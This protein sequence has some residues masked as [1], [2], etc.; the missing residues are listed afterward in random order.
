MK[1]CRPTIAEL[2]SAW[3]MGQPGSLEALLC[4]IQRELATQ[5]QIVA[6]REAPSATGA[7]DYP[8]DDPSDDP[9]DDREARELE[10]ITPTRLVHE[11]FLRL[12][13]CEAL[14]PDDRARFFAAAARLLRRRVVETARTLEAARSCCRTHLS[15]TSS[16][17]RG[18]SVEV[19]LLALDQAMSQ[20]EIV[21]RRKAELAELRFFVGL[22]TSE[23][24]ALLGLRT[25]TVER[26]WRDARFWLFRQLNEKVSAADGNLGSGHPGRHWGA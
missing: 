14:E 22:S 18:S 2:L 13:R 19:D 4:V 11:A 3:T 10:E 26:Q 25:A 12:V 6:E 7:G 16:I 5:A 9:F 24:A 8:F 17:A 21:D 1:R 15:P 20:L 23:A